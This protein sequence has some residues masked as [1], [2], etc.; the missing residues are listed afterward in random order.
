MYACM[1][2]THRERAGLQGKVTS[3]CILD[4]GDGETR[5]GGGVA[6]DVDTSRSESSCRR[7]HLGLAHSGVADHQ[8]VDVRALADRRSRRPVQ[9]AE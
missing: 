3:R 8:H 9:R 2:A 7:E 1:H 6:T 4:D 5:G